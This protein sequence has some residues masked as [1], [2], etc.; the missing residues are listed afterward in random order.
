MGPTKQAV[1][2][3]I[4]IGS[5]IKPTEL[6]SN[7]GRRELGSIRGEREFFREKC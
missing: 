6:E 2:L 7:I 1:N 3:I 4:F 5:K